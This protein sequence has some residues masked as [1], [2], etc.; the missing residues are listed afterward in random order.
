M[1]RLNLGKSRVSIERDNLPYTR[2]AMSPNSSYPLVT[3]TVT[4]PRQLAPTM[5]PASKGVCITGEARRGRQNLVIGQVTINLQGESIVDDF[6]WGPESDDLETG[7]VIPIGRINVFVGM[8]RTTNS[9]YEEDFD[10]MSGAATIVHSDGEE[11][12]GTT[13]VAARPTIEREQLE[14][15]AWTPVG[16]V[17]IDEDIESILPLF[18]DCHGYG[19]EG[20]DGYESSLGPVR[21]VA[22]Y[23]APATNIDSAAVTAAANAAATALARQ[24]PVIQDPTRTRVD[25]EV[26]SATSESNEAARHLNSFGFLMNRAKGEGTSNQPNPALFYNNVILDPNVLAEMVTPENTVARGGELDIAH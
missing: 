23:T 25:G 19:S 11:L 6:G 15:P 24:S 18:E 4:I 12:V 16:W 22:V 1:E 5:G 21:R 10:S 14:K 26:T 17:E 2:V 3:S 20:D 13:E 8:V 7:S 9:T